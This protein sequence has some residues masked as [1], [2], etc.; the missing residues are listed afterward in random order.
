[1]ARGQGKMEF[2]DDMDSRQT[3]NEWYSELMSYAPT[4]LT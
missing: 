3:L 2:P 1:M 4:I